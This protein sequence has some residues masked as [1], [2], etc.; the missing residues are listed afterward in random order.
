MGIRFLYS[1][2]GPE[3]YE[4][5][6]E[7]GSGSFVDRYPSPTEL[8]SRYED[9]YT[10]QAK[11]LRAVPF[12]IESGK[13][14]YYYQE[15]A[16][17]AATD[18]IGSG[19]DRAL[20][21][22][23]T[24]TGKTFIA[25]QIVHKIFEARWNRS[26]FGE[27]RPRVL[28]LADRN[29]L[30][31]QAINTFNPYEGDLIKI[32]G[33]EVR[34]RNGVVP[35]NAHLFFAIYQAIAEREDIGGYYKEYPADFFDLI[36]IDECHRGA[37]SEDGSWR[38]ILDHFEPAVHLGLTAT[39]KR[40]DNVDTYNY[41]GKPIYEYALKDGINDGFLTPYRV[42]RVRTNLDELILTDGDLI[43]KGESKKDLYESTD[44]DKAIIA[45][46]RTELVAK[47]ILDN[48]NPLEKTI[49]FCVNQ[50][51]ALTMRD[52]LNKHKSIK[53]P[54]YCVRVTSDE[55]KEGRELLEQF[56]DNDK[57]IP[58]I[59]TSSQML[60]TGVDA[61]N[62]RNIVLD[63]N[64]GS[65]VEFKQIVGRGTRVFEGKDYFTIID[66]RG[67]TNLFYD[68]EWDGTTEEPGPDGVEEP[69]PGG[70]GG[71]G[72]GPG[73]GPEP[74]EET[75]TVKLSPTRQLKVIDVDTRYIDEDGRPLTAQQFL[76]RLMLKL[77]DLFS[78]VDDLRERW[79]NPDGR[80]LLLKELGEAGFDS[81]QL[82]TLRAM[83][84]AEA[85][86]LFDLLA[87]LTHEQPMHTRLERAAKTRDSSELFAR[88]PDPNAQ[89]FL[90]FVLEKYEQTGAVELSRKSLARLV[91]LSGRG[92]IAQLSH[93]F[94]GSAEDLLKAFIELQRELYYCV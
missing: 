52:M 48:I 53:D 85:C 12:H 65:M 51:H 34:R 91:Q 37:A 75:L 13:T 4:F 7:E 55:G 59:L 10:D 24:G 16:V 11:A 36:V 44:Y 62:V 28:F 46:E 5:D 50:N 33:E 18:A 58:T 31:D 92:T 56:Q 29:V 68:P 20:L 77:P 25:F 15:L 66:F 45:N 39:P 76:E 64:I 87:F 6:L 3:I 67:A 73:P 26:S 21:T 81:E 14:P 94:G 23:A 70:G 42:K 84:E 8:L 79:A 40:T 71:G 32:N 43:L 60:T 93:A 38:A 19:M 74:P 22:L 83:F 90:E 61:R 9:G 63:R 2:N 47:A 88:Y 89:A 54:L 17:H 41:F 27:R 72:G 1:T 57:N 69:P 80:E 86:D 35:T 49:V 78:T 82:Q 30:A